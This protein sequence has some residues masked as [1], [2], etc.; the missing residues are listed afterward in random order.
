MPHQGE[1]HSS[2]TSL[3]TDDP[4]QGLPVLLNYYLDTSAS[5]CTMQC[6]VQQDVA[7]NSNHLLWPKLASQFLGPWSSA[8]PIFPAKGAG[9]LTPPLPAV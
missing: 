7:P 4:V 1:T 5:L 3:S 2:A 8:E 6:Q 9:K